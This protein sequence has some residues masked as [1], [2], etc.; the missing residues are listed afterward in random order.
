MTKLACDKCGHILRWCCPDCGSESIQPQRLVTKSCVS[1]GL[2]ALGFLGPADWRTQ[3][4]AAKG[5][6]HMHY[7]QFNAFSAGKSLRPIGI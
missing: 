6:D 7:R 4:L 1:G 5:F 2:F 3:L